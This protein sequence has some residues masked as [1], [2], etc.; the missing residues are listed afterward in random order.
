[1]SIA[2]FEEKFA[3]FEDFKRCRPWLEAALERGE[4]THG[5]D[6]ICD[7]VMNGNMTLLS[8]DTAA[9]VCVVQSAPLASLLHVFL[10]GG[11]LNG[12]R[13]MLPRLEALAE[14]LGCRDITLSG[15]RGWVKA[16]EDL[17][18][19]EASTN[20]TLRRFK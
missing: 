20:M 12:V 3:V 6:D 2:F 14:Q 1:M 9:L 19:T 4:M 13:A 7:G 11:E 8:S 18:F 5:I 10:A 17:G 15:R 16:L